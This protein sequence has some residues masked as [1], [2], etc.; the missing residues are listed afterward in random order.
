MTD[1]AALTAVSVAPRRSVAYRLPKAPARGLTRRIGRGCG[2]VGTRRL[3]V[4]WC[5]TTS[6]RPP[7]AWFQPA[8]LSLLATRE[9]P[10]V[11]PVIDVVGVMVAPRAAT[12]VPAV[13]SRWIARPRD[14]S[15]LAIIG[16]VL[17]VGMWWR[18]AAPA[19]GRG[20]ALTDAGRLTGFLAGYIALLQVLLRAR[21]RTIERTLGTDA[22]NTAH[23]VLG[24][25]LLALVLA[26]AS[27]INAGYAHRVHM[28]IVSQFRALLIDYPY[29]G[30]AAIAA[31]LLVGVAATS[32][33]IIRRRL[34]YEIWH[35]MHLAV[36]AALVLAFFHQVADGEHFVHRPQLR[37][38]WTA[39]W[40]SV[41][42]AIVWSRW[43]RPV[44]MMARHRLTVAA[45]RH[46]TPGTI[47]VEMTGRRLDRFP[48][49]P[50][51]Y[52]RWRFLNRSSWHVAHPYSLSAEPDGRRLRITATVTGRYSARLPGLR[53]GTRVM[54]EGP[55][56]GLLARPAWSGPVLLI[57]GGLGITPLRT[58]LATCPGSPITLI[59]RGHAAS[60]MPLRA[61][62]AEIADR[63][64]AR[65]HHVVGSRH[66]PAN[67]LSPEQI[68]QLCP[69]VGQAQVYVC[70]SAAFVRHVR[71]SL[72][73]LQVRGGNIRAESF[74]LA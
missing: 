31:S 43:L 35:G 59:Y 7:R 69:D 29:V 26:H 62:L 14:L 3:L 30:W 15:A 56:G 67:Q 52:F 2:Q 5:T 10:G 58:L 6:T 60:A 8:Q 71:T 50:G 38:A 46:E 42:A 9:P 63:R 64:H 20:A 61:E 24:V 72:S 66:D 11:L 21:L 41:A 13:G 1:G 45:I 25:Y 22:I 39:L 4:C 23:R 70:G 12:A 73:K 27:L 49:E 55:C 40:L 34:R 51:Q 47:S 19:V 65:L 37:I 32:V 28:G 36:Y 53:V 16:A 54:A 44:L 68:T 74:Q 17:L 18:G 57:A 33:P 48:A